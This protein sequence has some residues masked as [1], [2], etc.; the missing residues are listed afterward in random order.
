MVLQPER[1]GFASRGEAYRKG[2]ASVAQVYLIVVSILAIA[3]LYEA[4]EVIHLVPLFV[5]P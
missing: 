1:Y 3:A 4:F 5:R 2:L